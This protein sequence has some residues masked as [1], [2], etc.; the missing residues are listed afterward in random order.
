MITGHIVRRLVRPV[1]RPAALFLL[2]S[3]RRTI[4]LWARSIRSEVDRGRKEGHDPQR[5]KTL[6]SALWRVSKET[7][8]LQEN[9]LRRV[10]VADDDQQVVA[11]PAA[12][13][14][15]DAA[16]ACA[17]MERAVDYA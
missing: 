2:W 7:T 12:D 17:D 3:H 6:V 10:V 8:L 15:D 5:W 11:S 4:A 13:P 1:S 9:E 14:S 16:V